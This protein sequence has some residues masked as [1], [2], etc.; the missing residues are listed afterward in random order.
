MSLTADDWFAVRVRD[1]E[2]QLDQRVRLANDTR[3]MIEADATD[4]RV[5]AWFIAIHGTGHGSRPGV[6]RIDGPPD[7]LPDHVPR[8]NS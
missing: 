7:A 1:L 6:R 2:A 8:H 4:A 5:V 3:R